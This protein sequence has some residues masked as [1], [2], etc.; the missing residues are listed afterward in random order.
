MRLFDMRYSFTMRPG[1]KKRARV[2][3]ETTAIAERYS[4][5]TGALLGGLTV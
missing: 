2:G 4:H 3:G 1:D 5:R